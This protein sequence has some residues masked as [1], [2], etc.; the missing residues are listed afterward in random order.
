MDEATHHSPDAAHRHQC[1]PS[2]SSSNPNPFAPHTRDGHHYDPVYDSSSWYQHH[3]PSRAAYTSAENV[4][5]GVSPFLPI[6]SWQSQ[7]IAEGHSGSQD[8]TATFRQ[9]RYMGGLPWNEM[10]TFDPSPFA[11]N[12]PYNGPLNSNNNSSESASSAS[13]QT[14]A[15]A[16]TPQVPPTYGQDAHTRSV[17]MSFLSTFDDECLARF[18]TPKPRMCCKVLE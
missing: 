3:V 15:A 17:W 1:Q 13:V 4:Q 10:R 2:Q 16:G 8:P 6:P 14:S 12:P 5:W 7:G 11:F 9:S 18:R